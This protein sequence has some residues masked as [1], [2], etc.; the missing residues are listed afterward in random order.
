ML[1]VRYV[2]L[3]MLVLWLG[4][5]MDAL[6]G[7]GVLPCSSGDDVGRLHAVAYVAGTTIIACF[8]VMKL[9]GPP[10][11]AFIPRTIIVVLMLASAAYGDLA[12]GAQ[13]ISTSVDAGLGLALLF[14]YVRE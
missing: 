4:A 7:L 9:V 12:H 13:A 3:A 5:M 1:A 2:A 6:A 11:H 8:M 10:P 14:W